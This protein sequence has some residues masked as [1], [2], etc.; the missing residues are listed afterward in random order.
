MPSKPLHTA[1]S[2]LLLSAMTAACGG[3]GT[4]HSGPPAQW[5][6]Y[7][8]T[9]GGLKYSPLGEITP[10]NVD[11]LEIA[12]VHHHGDISDGSDGTT[13]TSFNATPIMVDDSLYFQREERKAPRARKDKRQEAERVENR[14][15]NIG[16]EGGA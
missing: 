14:A 9:L 8:G 11:D 6:H 13:R 5:R 12:W 7:G 1:L 10:E 15:L 16:P 3:E 2:A 4:P